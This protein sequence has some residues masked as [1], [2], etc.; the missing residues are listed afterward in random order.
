MSSKRAKARLILRLSVRV[1]NKEGGEGEKDLVVLFSLPLESVKARPIDPLYFWETQIRGVRKVTK[2]INRRRTATMTDVLER[3]HESLFL[4]VRSVPASESM[5]GKSTT[6]LSFASRERKEKKKLFVQ[7][8]FSRQHTWLLE[9]P[10][11]PT[12]TKRSRAALGREA[13]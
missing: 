4:C 7:N 11:K 9:R 13:R 3:Q 6:L 2:G 10:R 8:D 1:Q 12:S 5:K